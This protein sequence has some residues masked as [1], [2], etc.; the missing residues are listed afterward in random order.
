MGLHPARVR[1]PGW[2]RP[3][4]NQTPRKGLRWRTW[5]TCLCSIGLA[6][7]SFAA[8]CT[9]YEGTLGPELPVV[10]E[11][12]FDST[13]HSHVGRYFHKHIGVDIPVRGTLGKLIEKGK[14]VSDH[15]REPGAEW[16]GQMRGNDYSGVWKQDGTGR[17]FRFRLRRVAR[18]D[19]EKRRPGASQAIS[20]AISPGVGAGVDYDTRIAPETTPYEYRKVN[21]PMRQGKE[22]GSGP[23]AYRMVVDPRTQFEYPRLARHP[24]PD[25]LRRV[26]HLLEQRHW[27]MMLNALACAATAYDEQRTP[28]SGSLGGFDRESIT[29]T[30]LSPTLMTVIESGSTFCGGAH[31][32]NHFDPFTLDLIK[33][34]YV[35]LNRLF[36]LYQPA[37]PGGRRP[38]GER[39]LSPALLDLIRAETDGKRRGRPAL[40]RKTEE[41]EIAERCHEALPDY[42]A[43]YFREPRQ[44]VFGISGIG[45]AGGVCLGDRITL[46]FDRL[47]PVRRPEAKRYLDP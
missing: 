20:Q 1:D 37:G 40:D 34:K 18:Y 25:V 33:G 42:L 28:A 29:V 45:H 8:E 32:N 9:V 31:P 26:N 27:H 10:L 30:Y 24:D 46:P 44:L 43:M 41:D 7:A 22:V 47:R 12:C 3:V 16:Q 21:V 14:M 17:E 6:S 23:A 2:R 39:A 15:S 13:T 5:V 19:P 38:T 4:Q 11:L 35:D 36:K